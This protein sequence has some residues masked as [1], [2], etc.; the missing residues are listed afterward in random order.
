MCAKHINTAASQLHFPTHNLCEGVDV[1]EAY[2]HG[3]ND[4]TDWCREPQLAIERDR[5]VLSVR[6]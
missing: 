2:Q 4:G 5:S 3:C 6:D 1:C